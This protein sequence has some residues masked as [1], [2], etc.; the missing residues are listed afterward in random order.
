[1]TGLL[2]PGT[3]AAAGYVI[4][5]ECS[6]RDGS[7]CD[8]NSSELRNFKLGTVLL[9]VVEAVEGHDFSRRTSH[10]MHP[11]GDMGFIS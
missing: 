6:T 3:V 7:R 1:M 8:R 2:H 9:C 5:F 4:F 11:S 10:W